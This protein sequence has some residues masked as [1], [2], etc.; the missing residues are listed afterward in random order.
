MWPI[1]ETWSHVEIAIPSRG[2]AERLRRETWA[3]LDGQEVPDAT[4]VVYVADGDEEKAYRAELPKGA[5]IVVG[6]PGMLG[7]RQFMQRHHR[8]GQPVFHLDDDIKGFNRMH[9]PF[10]KKQLRPFGAGE[11]RETVHRGFDLCEANSL[12]LWGIYPASNP[13]F[14]QRGETVDLRFIVGYAMGIFNRRAEKFGLTLEVK[15]DYERTIKHYLAE[16]GVVRLNDVSA[17]TKCYKGT[18]GMNTY[19][20]PDMG[21]RAALELTTR[22]PSLCHMNARRKGEWAEVLLKDRR[23]KK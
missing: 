6:E 7:I 21:R 8:E 17:T 1:E 22:W 23:G 18:G 9:V 10:A 11:L 3:T 12:S 16:G 15:S 13:Y 2:R 4:R 20:T 5:Q 14:M 19:R